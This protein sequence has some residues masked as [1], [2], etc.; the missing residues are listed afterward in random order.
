M[1]LQHI[2][3]DSGAQGVHCGAQA[4]G[5]C[6]SCHAPVCGD[7]CTLTEGGVRVW[8]I[9]L[10]CEGRKGQSLKGAWTGLLLWLVAILVG[11]ALVTWVLGRLVG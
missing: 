1:D 9:C 11:L 8:A 4:V 10:A 2:D 7:C 3:D 5:P 6:A